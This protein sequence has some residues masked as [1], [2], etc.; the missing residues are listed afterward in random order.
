MSSYEQRSD[1]PSSGGGSSSATFNQQS[2]HRFTR[3]MSSMRRT[4]KRPLD[5]VDDVPSDV[6]RLAKSP[7]IEVPNK[8]TRFPFISWK[9]RRQTVTKPVQT[10]VVNA[11]DPQLLCD[12]P[13]ATD[14]SRRPL[15]TLCANS[16]PSDYTTCA[17][18]PKTQQTEISTTSSNLYCCPSCEEQDRVVKKYYELLIKETTFQPKPRRALIVGKTLFNK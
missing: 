18:N 15:E 6:C 13:Q 16:A 8:Q 7:R 1:G 11:G 9:L 4:R 5:V 14:Q 17:A 2:N 10:T 3:F 12:R